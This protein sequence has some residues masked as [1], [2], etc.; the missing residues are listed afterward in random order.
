MPTIEELR[1]SSDSA[2]AASL[3]LIPG[4]RYDLGG[5][6]LVISGTIRIFSSGMGATIDGGGLSRLVLVR[7]SSS[8]HLESVRL[9]NG[10]TSDQSGGGALF[11]EP[12]ANVTLHEVVILDTYASSG[13][14]L[15]GGVISTFRGVV[16]SNTPSVTAI[17]SNVTIIN[18]Q[19]SAQ[20]GVYGG[21]FYLSM[22]VAA[23]FS[24][25]TIANVQV[26]AGLVLEGA[27][28]HFWG[29][30]IATFSHGIITNTSA[31]AQGSIEGGLFYLKRDTSIAL[32]AFDITHTSV[33]AY[34]TR[35]HGAIISVPVQ[36]PHTINIAATVIHHTTAV[37]AQRLAGG[38]LWLGSRSSATLTDCNIGH[39]TTIANGAV[40]SMGGCFYSQGDLTLSSTSVAACMAHEGG[41]FFI[42]DGQ[43]TLS[44]GTA[45]DECIAH[46]GRTL[47]LQE[48]TALYTLPAPAARWTPG[49]KC[50]VYR[51]ACRRT[52][53][54]GYADPECPGRQDECR[55][56]L[57]LPG[58]DPT[59]TA[60][61]G[62]RCERRYA[63]Q[64]CNWME[65]A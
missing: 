38:V 46:T 26:S 55:G 35:L 7:A 27:I 64:P 6:P 24:N 56:L 43:L 15:H 51:Q 33:T 3:Y 61:D 21:V 17:F 10:F 49:V 8:L 28:A 45:V 4:A 1:A 44:N 39:T 47:F 62:G 14:T 9:T 19:V 54:G 60:S 22:S 30:A 63:L 65:G 42:G 25:V 29:N 50:E 5:A 11:I 40:S 2:A 58:N 59:P 18:V 48:G 53:S 37:A 20:E 52:L 23:T 12:N 57:D 34:G 36:N 32:T 41:C 16:G 13:A 31:V